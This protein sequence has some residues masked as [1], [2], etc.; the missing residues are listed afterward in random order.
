M[1]AAERQKVAAL[2]RQCHVGRAADLAEELQRHVEAI[3]DIVQKIQ[4]SPYR[5]LIDL[6]SGVVLIRVDRH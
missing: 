3:V 6:D 2:L 1:K 4:G 5:S